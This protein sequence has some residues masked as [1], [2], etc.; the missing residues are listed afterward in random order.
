MVI[1][2]IKQAELLLA[3]REAITKASEVILEI[4]QQD[5]FSIETKKDNSPVTRADKESS[6]IIEKI[7]L[8]K[9]NAIVVSEE[10]TTLVEQN[11]LH[12]QTFWLIDP[13]DGTKHFISK[14]G[15]FS[16][17]LA[18]ISQGKVIA[19]YVYAPISKTF[20]YAVKG[21]GAYKIS[22]FNQPNESKVKI[23]SNGFSFQKSNEL[24]ILTGKRSSHNTQTIKLVDNLKKDY[25]IEKQCF[26]S[27]LK[28]CQIAE[29]KVDLYPRIGGTS[30][31]D[32]AAAH[33]ILKEAG[34]NIITLPDLKELSVLQN[35]KDWGN[36]HFIACG[37]PDIKWISDGNYLPEITSRFEK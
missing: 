19:G 28:M 13:V 33:I 14:D 10:S 26:G 35:N 37:T 31:W 23:Q 15:Q 11:T 6:A 4:Y 16:V 5:D 2:A 9:T 3:A 24:K 25:K 7:L 27:S 34:G 17:N 32:T 8:Q 21:F 22:D 12:N 18:L 29:G 36:P 30:E 1:D 20:Y